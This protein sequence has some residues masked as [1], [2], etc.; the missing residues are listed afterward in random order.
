MSA[1]VC[2]TM[3]FME[4]MGLYFIC[5]VKKADEAICGV[6]EAF[7]RGI[8]SRATPAT[9]GR[10]RHKTVYGECSRRNVPRQFATCDEKQRAVVYG[11]GYTI[12]AATTID[13]DQSKL[14]IQ[15][16]TILSHG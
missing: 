11:D 15:I 3:H 12:T 14:E 2:A 9:G 1:T 13:S 4:E 7:G 5:A 6:C 10:E 8:P 16:I